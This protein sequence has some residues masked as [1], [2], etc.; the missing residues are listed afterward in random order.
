[1]KITKISACEL[2]PSLI[3]QWHLLQASN[4]ELVNPY[5]NVQYTQSVAAAR[6]DVYV[7]VIEQG[8]EVVGFFPFQSANNKVAEPVGG[9]LS[10]YHGIIG[11]AGQAWDYDAILDACNI[12]VWSFDH[13][14]ASQAPREIYRKVEAVSPI[15]DLSGGYEAYLQQRK[16][17]GAKRLEQFKRKARKFEREVG[18]IQVDV[19]CRNEGAFQQVI[20][21]KNAQCRNTGVPEFLNWGWT[22]E[23]LREIWQRKSNDFAGMLTILSVGNEIIAGHFG[24][25][26][27]TVCHWW[28]PTYNHAYAK[29]S[30]GGILLLKLAEAAAAEGL[31]SIDLGK[32]EDSYKP[33]FATDSIPL[34]E[35]RVLRPS[36]R[37]TIHRIKTGS[38]EFL[39]E[40]SV[41]EPLRVSVRGAKSIVRNIRKPKAVAL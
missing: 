40:S 37:S 1:M 2:D 27:N 35:G 6:D 33:S 18:E 38:R 12:K 9:R 7:A 24:M 17:S 28:F 13:L 20:E 14:L 34:V 21:W 10:D 31:T 3:S 39:R 5:F 23:M 29:Y 25:R 19:Y 32:G 22:S 26:S 8:N 15:M 30:P 4:P 11:A 16:K 41:T 36:L